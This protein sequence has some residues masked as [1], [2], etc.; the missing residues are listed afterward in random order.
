MANDRADSFEGRM[1]LD[2][3]GNKIGKVREVYLDD[4]T[5]R[6]KW[7]V[8]KT[9]RI[10]KRRFFPLSDVDSDGGDL[11]LAISKDR[12]D[13]A[14]DV[15][16]G[17]HLSPELESRLS[18][19]YDGGGSD[20]PRRG[21]DS[22]PDGDSRDNRQGAGGTVGKG[23]MAAARASQRDEFGGFNLGAALLGW[24]VAG[25]IAAIL[26][27]IISGAG[28][29]IGLTKV[30][31]STAQANAGTVSIVG[32]IV[33]VL[34]LAIA[35]YVGGYNAGRL[36]RFDGGRQ[37]LGVWLVGLVITLLLG[38]MG[39][40]FGSQY[41]V[42]QKIDVQPRVPVDEGSFATGGLIALVVVIVITIVAAIVG[43]KAGERYHKKVDRAAY[44]D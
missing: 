36:S 30:S 5:D 7:G 21:R 43:G 10:A 42:L 6:P 24:L 1:V 26:T 23:T 11:R 39:A 12:I 38:A 17:E 9:G 35:Y 16:E 8:V 19:H 29:A 13:D 40:I 20:R 41:N 14:P 15:A 28:A 34:V 37:G 32:A 44:G 3:D 33:L 31:G 22:V 18:R 27:A 2:R 25:G 4:Q